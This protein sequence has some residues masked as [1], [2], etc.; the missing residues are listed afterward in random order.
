MSRTLLLALVMLLTGSLHK[1][2]AQEVLPQLM[3]GAASPA[4]HQ[5]SPPVFQRRSVTIASRIL[6]E[7]RTIRLA[8][9]PSFGRT[10]PARRYPVFVVLD[11]EYVMRPVLISA[12]ELIRQ[13][14]MPEAVF[15]AIENVEGER[16]RDLTPPGLSVSGSSRNEGGD[17]FLDFIAQELLPALDSQFRTGEPRTLVGMSSGGILATYAAATRNNFRLILSLD[18]PT[19]LDEQWLPK[20][21]IA[22]AASDQN[23]AAAFPL[24][25]AAYGARFEWSADAWSRL[26]SAAPTG[27]KLHYQKLD[28]ETHNSMPMLGAYLGLRELFK[29][30]SKISAPE[31]PTTAILPYYEKL[32]AE[33]GAP[34]TAP[35]SLIRQ[36]IDDL[37]SEGRG[38]AAR[39]AFEQMSKAFGDPADAGELRKII[40]EA[41]RQPPP[42]ETVESVLATAFPAPAEVAALIG[43]WSGASWMHPDSRDPIDL[44]IQVRDGRVY[45]QIIMHP[46]P[47]ADLVRDLQYLKVE[48]DGFTY[49]YMNGMRPRGMLLFTVR[50][51][52]DHFTGKLRWGGVSFR[53]PDGEAPP[54]IFV[55]LKKVK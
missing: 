3:P 9:P 48:K 37:I 49:G 41:E 51:N 50:K 25:Y 13:G 6:E 46:E 16:L 20:K 27:W 4:T 33:Y 45:G 22:R 1:L 35:E 14:Q 42:T 55:E 38:S 17:R 15:A 52:G 34:M 11:G 32:S 44:K 21:L 31:Y 28:R 2:P 24:H 23:G 29:T 30:Y 8:L 39:V 18:G 19:H 12:S 54:D 7:K 36:V 43:D 40:A 10:S 5:E 47:G 53:G 26:T